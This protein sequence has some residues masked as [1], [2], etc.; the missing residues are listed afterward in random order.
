[1]LHFF[2]EQFGILGKSTPL[3][4]LSLYGRTTPTSKHVRLK[5]TKVGRPQQLQQFKGEGFKTI[6]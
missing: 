5:G 4:P 1:M 2:S 6:W 3:Y